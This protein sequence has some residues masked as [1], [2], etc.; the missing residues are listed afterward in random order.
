MN[1]DAYQPS[2]GDVNA[3]VDERTLAL[4]AAGIQVIECVDL[5]Q[6]HAS[7]VVLATKAFHAFCKGTAQ[8]VVFLYRGK[9]DVPARIQSAIDEL[10]KEGQETTR[11]L[12]AFKSQHE[13]LIEQAKAV[14]PTHFYAEFTLMHH[15]GFVSCGVFAQAYVDLL[16]ALEEFGEIEE[17]RQEEARESQLARDA[18]AL[19]QLADELMKDPGF[20][21]LR[22]KRKRCAYVAER[23]GLRV[24]SHRSGGLKYVDRH[25]NYMDANLVSL[26]ER[27]SD[28]LAVRE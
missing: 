23:Y 7:T 12:R 8:Q 17:G 15:G 2:S 9:C 20:A 11:M 27:V 4:D 21:A 18:E 1:V 14:C 16:T 13:P 26:V 6:E 28:R 3:W 24:P 5:F 22:G 25:S 19:E 10:C